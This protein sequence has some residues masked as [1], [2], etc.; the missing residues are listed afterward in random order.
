MNNYIKKNK[1]SMKS[2]F[3]DYELNSLPYNQALIYKRTYFQY[4]ISLIR[5]KHPFIFSFCPI[6]DYNS[7]IIKMSIFNLFFS[8]NYAINRVFFNESTIHKIYEDKGFYNFIY[9][10]PQIL[11]SFVISHA[12]YILIKYFFLS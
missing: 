8:V 4:Y 10:V 3:N 11:Y 9:L 7:I 12:F 1:K 2:I 5:T 6:N